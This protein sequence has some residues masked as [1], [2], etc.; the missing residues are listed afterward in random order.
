MKTQLTCIAL[1]LL[2]SV[3]ATAADKKADEKKGPPEPTKEQRAKMAGLHEKMAACL[4]TDKPVRDCHKEMM[5]SCHEM[6][7]DCPMMPGPHHGG[8]MGGGPMGGP[9]GMPENPHHQ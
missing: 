8:P 4:K 1:S 3:A 7:K 9:G 2:I 6:G 5:D